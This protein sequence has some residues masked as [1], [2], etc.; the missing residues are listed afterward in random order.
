MEGDRGA[1][2]LWEARK[3]RAASG[4]SK[5]AET[6]RNGEKDEQYCVIP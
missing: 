1:P 6:G 4:I 2:G 5:E 3:E